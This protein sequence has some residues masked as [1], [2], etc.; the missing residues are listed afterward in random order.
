MGKH[1]HGKKAAKRNRWG[2]RAQFLGHRHRR[3]GRR[4]RLL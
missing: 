4:L 1:L 3:R 2:K